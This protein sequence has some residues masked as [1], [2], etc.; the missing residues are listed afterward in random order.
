VTNELRQTRDHCRRMAAVEPH[1]PLW[2]QLAD[3]IDAHLAGTTTGEHIGHM[4]EGLEG[5][6]TL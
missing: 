2:T 3:E 1:E 5:V 4:L 6:G